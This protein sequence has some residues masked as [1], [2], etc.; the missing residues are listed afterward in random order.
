VCVDVIDSM[1]CCCL[2]LCVCVCWCDWQHALLLPVLVQH[3]LFHKCLDVLEDTID[4]KFNDRLLLQVHLSLV[5]VLCLPNVNVLLG[6]IIFLIRQPDVSWIPYVLLL[7]FFYFFI[8]LPKHFSQQP[9]RGRRQ[10]H[11]R[12]LIIGA[13]TAATGGSKSAIFGLIAQQCS[14]L[15]HC[16]LETEQDIFTI[17]KLGV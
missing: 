8:F 10:M 11:T 5:C 16:G 15:S 13:A 14:T 2:Y 12:G 3:L 17:F 4:Y 6:N 9:Q 1:H 7:S